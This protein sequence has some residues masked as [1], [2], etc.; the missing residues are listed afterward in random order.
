MPF[1]Q[2]I[3]DLDNT[4]YPASRGVVDRVD[5]R[6][7]RYMIERV[8]IA[9]DAAAPLRARYRDAYGTTLSGLMRHH[10]ID[11]D[12]YLTAIHEIAVEELLAPDAALGAMLTTLAQP[13]AVFTNGSAGHAERVLSCLGIRT[14]FARIFS[15]ESVAYVPKP[16]R[17]AF[18]TVLARLG[19]AG[20]DCVFVDDRPDNLATAR[21]LGMR[22]VLVGERSSAGDVPVDGAIASIHDLASL[23]ARF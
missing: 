6:I 17:I 23:L 2:L 13:K 4:L 15:L 7:N 14:H 20:R 1:T 5:D 22:T 9:P 21:A 12:D 11:P 16:E 10:A 8:G 19:A 18:E 3:F